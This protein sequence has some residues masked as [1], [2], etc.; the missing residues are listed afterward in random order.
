MKKDLDPRLRGDRLVRTAASVRIDLIL[1]GSRFRGN[2]KG[3][4]D[5]GVVTKN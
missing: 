5:D 1:L 4:E 3:C 2:D